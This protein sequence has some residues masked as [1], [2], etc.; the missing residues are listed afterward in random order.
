MLCLLDV[1][2]SSV[3]NC[4]V[5]HL[6]ICHFGAFLALLCLQLVVKSN[7]LRNQEIPKKNLKLLLC[8]KYHG[9]WI[10][11]WISTADNVQYVKY[12]ILAHSR[13]VK[14]AE[15]KIIFFKKFRRPSRKVEFTPF[16][17]I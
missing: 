3:D 9:Y 5:I 15:G 4:W 11:R 16:Y 2:L 7:F 1:P 13:D 6:G 12:V 10:F 17:Q 8:T 14:I